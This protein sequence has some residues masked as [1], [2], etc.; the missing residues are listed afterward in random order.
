MTELRTTIGGQGRRSADARNGRVYLRTH[1]G[2]SRRSQRLVVPTISLPLG[3]RTDAAEGRGA[4][5]GWRIIGPSA[6]FGRASETGRQPIFLFLTAPAA[7]P[8]AGGSL[9]DPGDPVGRVVEVAHHIGVGDGIARKEGIGG[10]WYWADARGWPRGAGHPGGPHPRRSKARRAA[11]RRTSRSGSSRASWALGSEGDVTLRLSGVRPSIWDAAPSLPR[12]MMV[13]FRSPI[14]SV[15]RGRD[16]HR[17][18]PRSPATPGLPVRISD[19]RRADS[20]DRGRPGVA[21]S[22]LRQYRDPSEVKASAESASLTSF[23]DVRG[24]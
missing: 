9:I 5:P 17:G 23:A 8:A 15:D 2:G 20:L 10:R 3:D 7:R 1:R 24:R 18:E 6:S 16:L 22:D 19:R 12:R 21:R 13:I 4:F 14:A 11:R